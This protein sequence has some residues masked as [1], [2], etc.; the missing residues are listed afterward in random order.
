MNEAARQEER[1]S[2]RIL[3]SFLLQNIGI[4][5]GFCIILIISIYHDDIN[6]GGGAHHH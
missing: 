6:L 2:G 3:P 4:I 5:F 1:A